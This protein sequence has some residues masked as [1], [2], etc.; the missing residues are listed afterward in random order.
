MK[1]LVNHI[2][3]IVRFLQV[4]VSLFCEICY[5][6]DVL[7]WVVLLVE[8]VFYLIFNYLL[9]YFLWD[10]WIFF[11][12]IKTFCLKEFGHFSQRFTLNK[13]KAN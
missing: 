7:I 3:S 5:P 6:Q 10:A 2:Q 13:V 4:F 1:F 9:L 11:E 8:K 12:P